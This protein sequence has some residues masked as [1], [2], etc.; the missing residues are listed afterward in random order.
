MKRSPRPCQLDPANAEAY[1]T[2]AA[3]LAKDLNA[4]DD[5]FASGLANCRTDTFITN[6]AAFG[7]LADAYHLHRGHQR[8][9]HRGGAQP[10]PASPRCSRSPRTTS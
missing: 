5:Q 2:T 1:Q 9:V 6:H 3:A 4:L 8:A 7:Y 10:G